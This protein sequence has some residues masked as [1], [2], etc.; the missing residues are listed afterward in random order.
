M[1]THIDVDDRISGSWFKMMY[2][3]LFVLRN[4]H[5]YSG[6]I[7]VTFTVNSLYT[8]NLHAGIV[9]KTKRLQNPLQSTPLSLSG[10]QC[11]IIYWI[12][13]GCNL[14]EIAVK[15]DSS[16]DTILRYLDPMV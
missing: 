6:V 8:V 7:D 16:Q 12:Q 11:Q 9:T 1:P 3:I 2:E 15:M 5:V 10:T 13:R 14:S 4:I